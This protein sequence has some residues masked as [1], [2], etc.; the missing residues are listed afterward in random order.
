MVAHASYLYGEV[1]VDGVIVHGA[2]FRNHLQNLVSR[3][4]RVGI[5]FHHFFDPS[6]LLERF[7]YKQKSPQPEAFPAPNILIYHEI[8]RY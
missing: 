7:V 2:V 8:R 4:K 3:L 6:K 1:F 5:V